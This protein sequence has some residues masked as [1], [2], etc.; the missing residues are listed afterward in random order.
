MHCCRRYGHFCRSLC[1]LRQADAA[2]PKGE[3]K[4]FL[5]ALSYD[6]RE[7]TAGDA[8]EWET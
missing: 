2:Y 8:S 1:D 4:G 6:G 7:R 3:A 5:L